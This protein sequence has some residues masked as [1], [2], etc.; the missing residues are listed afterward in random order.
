MRTPTFMTS[1]L[2]ALAL[3][4][5]AA[6]QEAEPREMPF[7]NVEWRDVRDERNDL[8][9]LR[10]IRDQWNHA[11][12]TRDRVQERVAD[13]RLRDWLDR[14]LRED[15]RELRESRRETR[16]ARYEAADTNLI[17]DRLDV[18]D[19]EHDEARALADLRT[20]RRLIRELGE[21]QHHFDRRTA[22]TALYARKR[23]MIERLIRLAEDE[24]RMAQREAQEDR[25]E[26]LEDVTPRRI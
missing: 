1:T 4:A 2:L 14:E 7:Q 10:D 15:V 13:R 26:Y 19:D 22:T 6:A 18:R 12:A 5:P 17:D 9:T 16:E 25:E 11:V 3:A 21:L 20:T 8:F 24:H 23:G